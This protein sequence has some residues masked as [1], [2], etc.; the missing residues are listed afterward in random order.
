MI[1]LPSRSTLKV[2]VSPGDDCD[3]IVSSGWSASIGWS[4]IFVM[5][6]P[7]FR[8]AAAAGPLATTA[9]SVVVASG[10]SC[11]HQINHLALVR[12]RHMAEV[13]ADALE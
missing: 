11:R 4:P 9:G 13:L 3:R 5:M 1:V 2:I 8:P 12:A 7:S 6:S 10:A